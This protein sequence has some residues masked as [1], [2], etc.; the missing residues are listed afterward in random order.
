LTYD[1]EEELMQEQSQ[2]VTFST[3]KRQSS[4]NSQFSTPVNSKNSR[5][6]SVS[7]SQ[8]ST[9][10]RSPVTAFATPVRLPV[11]PPRVVVDQGDDTDYK[12]R[13]SD[14]NSD[15]VPALMGDLTPVKIYTNKPA[16]PTPNLTSTLPI[17]SEFR[18]G[19]K[20]A[21]TKLASTLKGS[22]SARPR[23]QQKGFSID[24]DG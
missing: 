20:S 22:S 15:V 7:E 19:M 23:T 10:M 6:D 18:S 5:R 13:D 9:P 1:L 3:P 24:E 12:S 14:T 4:A 17:P 16:L 11:A 8:A 21:R 2:H